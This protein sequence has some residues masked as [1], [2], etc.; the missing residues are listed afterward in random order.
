MQG[1]QK[2][3]R[4]VIFLGFYGMILMSVEANI[5]NVS[6][7]AS[8]WDGDAGRLFKFALILDSGRLGKMMGVEVG[9][10]VVFEV[11]VEMVVKVV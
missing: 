6:Q 3:M 5:S 8:L 7:W 10:E 11:L 4:T 2:V 1:L 9:M